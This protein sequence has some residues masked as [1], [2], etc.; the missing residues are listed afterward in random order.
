MRALDILK[1]FISD[2]GLKHNV[3]AEKTKISESYLSV[4]LN[5][6]HNTSLSL[7]EDILDACGL[8]IHLI[9]KPENL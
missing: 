9:K 2:N 8:E 5:G 1:S 3:L 7:F 6:R 4:I